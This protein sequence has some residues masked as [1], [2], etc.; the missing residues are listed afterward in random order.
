MLSVS[1]EAIPEMYWNR[2]AEL[3]FYVDNKRA[4]NLKEALRVMADEDFFGNTKRMIGTLADKVQQ[5]KSMVS[6]MQA[7]IDR[8]DVKIA[9]A[10]LNSDLNTLITLAAIY[11]SR[12]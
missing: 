7:Q 8:M 4:D 12:N 9:Q 5:A 3:L 1:R 10:E 6:D 2:A 11:D